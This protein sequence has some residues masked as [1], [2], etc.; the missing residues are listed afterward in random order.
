VV[1]GHD[2]CQR[3]LVVDLVV[4]MQQQRGCRSVAARAELLLRDAERTGQLRVG[5]EATLVV[6]EGLL[7]TADLPGVA[8]GWPGRP[9]PRCRVESMIAPLIRVAA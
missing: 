3:V 5:G 8:G 9:S 4:Q 6:G 7:G 1:L 2:H